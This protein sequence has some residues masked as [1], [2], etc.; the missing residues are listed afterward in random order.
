VGSAGDPAT[1]GG[2]Q[3][4]PTSTPPGPPPGRFAGPAAGERPG[5]LPLR[6]ALRLA[7]LPVDFLLSLTGFVL[8]VTLLA[9]TVGLTPLIWLAVPFFLLLWSVARWLG[10]AERRRLL[11][12]F[13]T[14]TA[15]PPAAPPGL[16]GRLRD[17]AAWRVIGHLQVRWLYA[18]FAFAVTNALWAL[19]L[20]LISMPYWLHRVPAERADLAVM[21]VTDTTTAWLL[22]VV[23][24]VVGLLGLALAHVFGTASGAMGRA[25][26]AGQRRDA[27][28]TDAGP[29][30]TDEPAD[31]PIRLTAGRVAALAIGLPLLAAAAGLSA[32]DL[33]SLMAHTTE[34]H[35]VGYAWAGGPVTLS[36]SS[37][38]IRVVAGDATTTEVSVDYTARYGLRAP[39]V[40]GATTAEGGVA[41]DAD[42]P[43][44]AQHRCDVDYVLT[45]PP[46]AALT[47]RTGDGTI[48]VTG[49]TGD[50]DVRTSD[51]AVRL[52]T[53]ADRVSARSGDGS[54]SLVFT[55]PPADV[56]ARTSDGRVTIT[57][58]PGAA[59]AVDAGTSDGRTRVDVPT[60]PGSPRVLHA[61]SGDGNVTIAQAAPQ[62]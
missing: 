33:I 47:L 23:G 29:A 15:P 11:L 38:D 10:G 21:E 43:V 59:Y 41:L 8:T 32:T 36:T 31:D 50:L 62:P 17:R 13:G 2:G 25:M 30:A 4:P 34:R 42:C 54:I 24:V 61:R 27:P 58:P 12:Y 18:T 19:S 46:G 7:A 20:A 56:N 1:T 37:G 14:R 57:V 55:E 49:S 40:S 26:L 28:A 6:L 35:T 60:D 45:V 51:G 44:I 22:V 5:D 39:Q 52:T 9:V 48:E 16:R 53:A 3:P